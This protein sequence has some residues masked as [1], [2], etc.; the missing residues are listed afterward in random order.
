[1]TR[2]KSKYG[3]RLSISAQLLALP[4]TFPGED[5]L[6]WC[7]NA[8]ENL[9]GTQN[10]PPPD[11]EYDRAAGVSLSDVVHA[12]GSASVLEKELVKKTGKDKMVEQEEA[13]AGGVSSSTSVPTGEMLEARIRQLAKKT[14]ALDEE[15]DLPFID[16]LKR[17][18]DQLEEV[19]K[20]GTRKL[21][22]EEHDII[23][24]STRAQRAAVIYR[25]DRSATD[26][27]WY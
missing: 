3:K 26:N 8:Y 16:A 15:D 11:D 24:A 7:V 27:G 1:M 25:G 4:L 18:A 12:D 13:Q 10:I 21:S 23:V 14:P 5:H 6:S 22:P 19:Q 2:I 20:A 9:R 17:L